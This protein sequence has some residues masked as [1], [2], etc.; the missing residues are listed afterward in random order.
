MFYL[1]WFSDNPKQSIEGK[2]A[3][4]VAAYVARFDTRPTVAL[5][6]EDDHAPANVAGV[7]TRAERRIGRNNVQVGVEG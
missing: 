3:D 6:S 2:I 4:A 5:V 7:V 1:W